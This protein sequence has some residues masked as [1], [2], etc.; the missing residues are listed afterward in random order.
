MASDGNL[1]LIGLLLAL[2]P[3]ESGK[4]IGRAASAQSSLPTWQSFGFRGSGFV[5]ELSTLGRVVI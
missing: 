5:V 4:G 2:E 1:G 3:L